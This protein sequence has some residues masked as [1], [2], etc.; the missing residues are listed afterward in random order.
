MVAKGVSR[1][2]EIVAQVEWDRWER[3][4]VEAEWVDRD[5][6]GYDDL[7]VFWYGGPSGWY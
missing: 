3:K 5:D 7:D 1:L 4:V 6:F 2:G